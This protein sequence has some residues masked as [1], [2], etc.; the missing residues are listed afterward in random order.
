MISPTER[1]DRAMAAEDA[2]TVWRDLIA[3]GWQRA[4]DED[5]AR[6]A[7]TMKKLRELAYG[8]RRGRR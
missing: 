7:M 5:I 2:R 3:R 4:T 1:I 8:R 6:H